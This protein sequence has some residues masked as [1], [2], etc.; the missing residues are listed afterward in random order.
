MKKILLA[1]SII[2][3]NYSAIYSQWTQI[4]NGIPSNIRINI[5]KS[6][7]NNVYVG[8]QEN[9]IFISSN[10]GISFTQA[11]L[12]NSAILDIMIINSNIYVGTEY[13]N[14]GLWFSSN[15]GANWIQKPLTN[16]QVNRLCSKG[17]SIFAGIYQFGVRTS[18]NDGNNWTNLGMDNYHIGCLATDSSKL[19]AGAIYTMN[20][21]GGLFVSTNNGSNW[22]QTSLNKNTTSIIFKNNLLF[23]GCDNYPLNN[24]NGVFISSDGGFNWSQT[25]LNNK[26]IYTL[27]LANSNIYAG[28]SDNGVYISTNNGS[29]W[30]TLNE[31]FLTNSF[32]IYS[33][34]VSSNNIYAGTS[35]NGLWKRTIVTKI[36]TNLEGKSKEYNLS[37]NYPNPFNPI[38]KIKYQIKYSGNVILKIFNIQG[39]EIETLVNEKQVPGI[40]E[41]TFDGKKYSSG[42]YYC[43]LM[44]EGSARTCKMVLL[45]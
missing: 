44:I 28:T 24:G 33:L 11:G 1:I 29:Y 14:W 23:A 37:Q 27:A 9:G 34:S 36:T 20:T 15:N 10:N 40:Y 7:G 19:F 25:F 39:K 3:L 16:L 42:I 45:K 32:C 18:T 31:G 43:R 35:L 12:L 30:I 2:L 22:Y 41:M 21:N 6:N 13:P 38:T 8:T 4:T 17:S 5:V 26:N